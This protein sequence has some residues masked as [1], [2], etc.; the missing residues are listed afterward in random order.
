M[1]TLVGR[2]DRIAV[3][4]ELWPATPDARHW[5]FGTMCLWAAGRRIGRHDEQCALAV[6]LASFPGVLRHSGTRADAALMAMP[7]AK[8]F[9]TIRAA[10]YDDDEA[11]APGEPFDRFDVLPRSLDVFDGWHAFLIEDRIVARLLWSS[12]D[13]GIHEARIGAGEFDRTIED[14]LAFLEQASGRTRP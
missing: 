3:E 11:A 1:G 10:I 7:A 5:L 12:I 2:T 4:F 8:A 14:F 13:G 6:A 9:E